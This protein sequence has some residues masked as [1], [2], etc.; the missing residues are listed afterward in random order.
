MNRTQAGLPGLLLCS[1][2]LSGC[3]ASQPRKPLV[4]ISSSVEAR[5]KISDKTFRAKDGFIHFYGNGKGRVWKNGET[6]A[7]P[8]TWTIRNGAQL[9][10]AWGANSGAWKAALA[11]VPK[12]NQFVCLHY[13]ATERVPDGPERCTQVDTLPPEDTSVS[14]PPLALLSKTPTP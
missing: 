5:E 2:A 4:F 9:R 12:T 11:E 7:R 1:L 3:V 10:A 14:P 8:F 13:P 6:V